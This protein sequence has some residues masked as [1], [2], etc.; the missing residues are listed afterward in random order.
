MSF[1]SLR[2]SFYLAKYGVTN[3]A[4]TMAHGARAAAEAT[5]AAAATT[6]RADAAKEEETPLVWMAAWC[7][8]KRR[9][10]EG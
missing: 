4:A 1:S 3:A 9:N 7:S 2:P 8:P 6:R 10:N 5:V